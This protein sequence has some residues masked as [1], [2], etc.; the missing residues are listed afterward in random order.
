M[1]RVLFGMARKKGKKRSRYEQQ[2][3]S[4][5]GFEGRGARRGRSGDSVV[6]TAASQNA[7]KA[8]RLDVSLGRCRTSSLTHSPLAPFH[9]LPP[10]LVLRSAAIDLF[11]GGS[12]DNGTSSNQALIPLRTPP[13]RRESGG[14]RE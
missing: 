3:A 7:G 6:C 4:F 2:P 12:V 14:K 5:A 13:S 8:S 1:R 11:L 10:S 9:P